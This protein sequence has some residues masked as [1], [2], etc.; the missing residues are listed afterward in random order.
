MFLLFILQAAL[1]LG[2]VIFVHELGHFLVAKACGVKCEKFYV[3]FDIPLKFGPIRLPSALWRKKWGETEYGIGILPLGGY[4]KMLGQDDNPGHIAEEVQRSRV[5]DAE[6]T[7]GK[8]IVGPDGNT[9]LV[10]RRSYLAKSVPQRMAIIS[11]GV[12]MNIIFAFIFA[13]IAYGLGVPYIPC[14]VGATSPGSPAWESGLE[15]GDEIVVLEGKKDPSFTELRSGVTLSDL[16]RGISIRVKRPGAAED[17]FPLTLRPA[18]GSGLAMIGVAPASS[19]RL[20]PTPVYPFSAAAT[21][22]LVGGDAESGAEQLSA[23]DELLRIDGIAVEDHVQYSRLMAEKVGQPVEVTVRRGGEANPRNPYLPRTG[24]KELT[25]RVEAPLWRRLGLVMRMGKVVA[26]RQNSPASGRIEPNDFIQ[27]MN[28]KPIGDPLTWPEQVRRIAVQGGGQAWVN[29]DV[30]RPSE[31]GEDQVVT[32][33]NLQP[34]LPRW[35]DNPPGRGTPLDCPS[36]GIAYRVLNRVKSVVPGSPA[37]E[38]GLQ[39][40]DEILEAQFVVGDDTPAD[41]R[42]YPEIKLGELDPNWPWVMSLVQRMSPKS[43]LK[44]TVKRGDETFVKQLKPYVPNSSNVDVFDPFRGFIFENQRKIRQAHSFGEA[45]QLGYDKTVDSLLLVYQFLHR[46]WTGQIPVTAL[47]GPITIAKAGYYSG[48]EGVGKLLIFLTV[49]SANLAV[50]N[51]LPIPMLDGGHMA[52]LAYEGIRKRPPGEKFV[53]A[54]HTIGFAFI[55]S[56][57]LFVIVLDLGLIQRNL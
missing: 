23:G 30:A 57:M 48:M 31:A 14:E 41:L 33:D 22:R 1:G 54:L 3:G 49:L 36:L 4:V 37:D 20:A 39:G 6:T 43:E 9:Y 44:L 5:E 15:P 17:P 24:G 16:E 29:L 8:E 40:G 2:A 53:V 13:A 10:D 21:A 47:G 34:R 7:G 25:F 45:I 46:L 18:K 28:G 11:A 51:F 55:V 42:E 52:F 12:V 56:L 38:A 26:V 19:L 35:Q 32:I 50:I 27:Q